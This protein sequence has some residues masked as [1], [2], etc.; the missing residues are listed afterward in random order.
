MTKYEK[1]EQIESEK[2]KLLEEK[3]K[4]HKE[5]EKINAQIEGCEYKIKQ[6]KI[7]G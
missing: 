2:T 3:L 7:G 6:I 5:I 1:I 4:L